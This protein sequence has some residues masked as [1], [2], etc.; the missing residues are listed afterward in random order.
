MIPV[1]SIEEFN[2]LANH[3]Y[4][5]EINKLLFESNGQGRLIFVPSDINDAFKNIRSITS[6]T[7]DGVLRAI[8][9]GFGHALQGVMD[10]HLITSYN[11]SIE[12]KS[13]NQIFHGQITQK[14]GKTYLWIEGIV[15]Y[16]VNA[17]VLQFSYK[18]N[19]CQADFYSDEMT[20]KLI[21]NITKSIDKIARLP[22][23]MGK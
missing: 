16:K 4:H 17:E 20:A 23:F 6:D 19:F 21:K 7:L 2:S 1:Y 11:L 8:V 13:A 22:Q 10:Y 14:K 12:S 15:F 3:Y 18:H 9:Q 5:L